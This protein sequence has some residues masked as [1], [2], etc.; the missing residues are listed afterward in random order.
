MENLGRRPCAGNSCVSVWLGRLL[1]VAEVMMV[2]LGVWSGVCG[3]DTG[4]EVGRACPR[5]LKWSPSSMSV[6]VR[7]ACMRR[8]SSLSTAAMVTTLCR[9]GT[10][11]NFCEDELSTRASS[12]V[13]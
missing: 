2:L 10:P 1:G 9:R 5:G 12:V 4:A 11:E 3:E 13:M 7:R 8:S 6:P